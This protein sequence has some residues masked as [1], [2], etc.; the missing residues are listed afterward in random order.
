MKRT[1]FSVLSISRF[2]TYIRK[3]RKPLAMDNSLKWVLF[4]IVSENVYLRERI[5]MEGAFQTKVVQERDRG[6]DN[7][8]LTGNKPTPRSATYER[9]V[10]IRFKKSD[11]MRL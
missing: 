3:A 4:I 7:Q 2:S 8:P 9:A 5:T 10:G 11:T 6:S 1:H